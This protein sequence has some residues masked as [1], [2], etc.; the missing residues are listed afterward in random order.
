MVKWKHGCLQ[1]IYARVQFPPWPPFVKNLIFGVFHCT[2]GHLAK[3]RDFLCLRNCFLGTFLASGIFLEA[4]RNPE[5]D[6]GNM[7]RISLNLPFKK[8]L[9]LHVVERRGTSNS[10]DPIFPKLE[11]VK[12]AKK[13]SKISRYFTHVF[14]HKNIKK[15]FGANLTFILTVAVFMPSTP[16]YTE[17]QV[18]ENVVLE[19]SVILTTKNSVRYPVDNVV[20]SQGYKLFHPGVDFDGLTGDNIYPVMPGF[21][22]AIS[23]SKYAYGNAVTVNH[24]RG[25]TSL[26]AHLSFISVESG[27]KLTVETK[28]GEMGATGRATGDHLH[29]EIRENGIAINPFSIL[30]R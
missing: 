16:N 28:I 20:V 6:L 14:E 24:G 11:E 26:Y 22:E 7:I 4:K 25:L 2:L 17:V 27:Q 30:P 9:R 18:E 8:R 19:E 21:V 5:R 23:F 3:K 1:N 29:F 12:R 15:I 10:D 13:G